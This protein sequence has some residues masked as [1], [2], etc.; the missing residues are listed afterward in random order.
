MST[1]KRRYKCEGCG[2]TRPCFVET[3]QDGG[4]WWNQLEGLRCVLDE[5]NRTGYSWV[6]ISDGG[7][8]SG[9][10]ETHS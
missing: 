9:E 2:P 7:E 3:N 6:A 10:E 5:T 4:D 1:E 8:L